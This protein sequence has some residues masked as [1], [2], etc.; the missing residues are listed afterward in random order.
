MIPACGSATRSIERWPAAAWDVRVV[1]EFDNIET[2]KRAVEIDAGVALLPE[3]TVAREVQAGSLVV[4]PLDT[5][6]LVR[7]VGILQR[8]GRELTATARRFIELLQSESDHNR[9]KDVADGNGRA[10]TA[11]ANGKKTLSKRLLTRQ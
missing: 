5:D 10:A 6:E 7:P 9:A 4:L 11:Q 1:M 3:P 2:I 8:R